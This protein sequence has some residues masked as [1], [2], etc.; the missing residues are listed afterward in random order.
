MW[1]D[2]IKGIFKKQKTDSGYLPLNKTI[3]E[4]EKQK[5]IEEFELTKTGTQ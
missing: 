2:L 4:S 5:Y 1:I 3:T